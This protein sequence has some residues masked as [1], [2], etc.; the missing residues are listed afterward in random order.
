MKECIGLVYGFVLIGNLLQT[1]PR[2]LKPLSLGQSRN[3][4][5]SDDG[6]STILRKSVIH[7]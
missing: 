6:G 4:P 7:Q 2:T 3:Y 5:N 1:F